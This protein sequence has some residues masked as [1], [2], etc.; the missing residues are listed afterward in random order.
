MSY[1]RHLSRSIAVEQMRRFCK[2]KKLKFNKDFKKEAL[3]EWKDWYHGIARRAIRI[4]RR[5]RKPN[6]LERFLASVMIVG[7]R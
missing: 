6:A 4:N 5:L 3:R 7:G 1:I 2:S